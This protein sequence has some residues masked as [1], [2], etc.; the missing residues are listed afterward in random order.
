MTFTRIF[1]LGA[2]AIG[3][4]IGTALSK[5]NHVTLI[6]NKSHVD[7]VNSQGLTI[8][9]DIKGIFQIDAETHIRKIPS[10]ALIFLS[11]KAYD[12][13]KATTGIKTLLRKDTV[14]V[15]LQNG[16]GNEDAIRRTVN[17]K[18]KVLRAVTDMAA[19]FFK[20][21]HV[22]Y[23]K[24]ETVIEREPSGVDIAQIMNSCGLETSTTERI[25]DRLWAKAAV[26]SVVNPLTAIFRV[27]NCE[28]AAKSLAPVRH[29]I[30]RE[31]IEV[32]RKEGIVLQDRLEKKVDKE[33]SSYENYSSMYQDV[34]KGK[35]TEID[36][37][38]G[39]IVELG[40][41]N[42]VP[43]PANE[44]MYNLVKY[45]EEKNEISRHN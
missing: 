20:A 28:I 26:N 17:G 34:M 24:G 27:R 36:F 18:C 32:G 2:G 15:V 38:N 22:R 35:K 39:K 40:R 16:L 45:L 3:S 42:H 14:I 4:I 12:S 11:T 21:G 25:E 29:Q 7:V 44:T 37:L 30:V 41:K 19:E 13:E 1:I 5:E 31:C 33:I 23:W 6:G 8:S 9:G 43:T 10:G